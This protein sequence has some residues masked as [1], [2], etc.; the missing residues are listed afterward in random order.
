MELDES[1]HKAFPEVDD[2]LEL[3]LLDFRT[4]TAICQCWR[5]S[6][7]YSGKEIFAFDC[8]VLPRAPLEQIESVIRDVSQ[9]VARSDRRH[10][11]Q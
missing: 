9:T 5:T 1:L 4:D 6:T 3:L 7:Q 2:L 8:R 10:H 11:Q